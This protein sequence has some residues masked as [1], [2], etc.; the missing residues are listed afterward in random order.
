M[1]N[2]P[3]SFI[4]NDIIQSV[5]KGQKIITRFPPEPNGYMH[6]GHAKAFGLDYFLAAKYGGST[7]LRFEDTNPTKES[8][9]YVEAMKR[10]IKW[11]GMEWSHIVFISDNFEII[12]N[13][14]VEFIK[15]GLAYVD[16]QTP[17]EMNETRGTFEK[18]GVDSPH[19]NRSVKENLELF[20]K[21][22]KGE[23]K[24]GECVLR[25]KIDMQSPNLKM[26]DPA[27]YRIMFKHHMLTNDDWCIYPL[28]DYAHAMSDMLGKITHSICSLEYDDHRALYDWF[29]DHMI[30]KGAGVHDPGSPRP[31]QFEFSRLNIEQFVMSKRWLLKFVEEGVVDGWDDPRMPTISGMRRRGY[32]PMA[33]NEFVASTGVSRTP[34][35]VP[36]AQLEHFVRANLDPVVPRVSVVFNPVRV[37]ITNYTGSGEQLD[38]QNNPHKPEDGT[39]K[40]DFS[41]EI[42]ID[43]EDFIVE[44]PKGWKR[45]AP[46]LMVRLR[47]AYIIKCDEVVYKG[48]KIDHLKCT[49][50]PESKSGFDTSGVKPNGVIHY[51]DKKT[52]K[53]IVVN[54][55]FPLLKQGTALSEENI[56]PVTKASHEAFAEK[57]LV[58]G[59]G[60]KSVQFVR[61][62][63]F[64]KD[65]DGAY[66]KTV[67]L[68]G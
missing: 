4:E 41:S 35:T 29:I 67:S 59:A 36:M 37:V 39:H 55:F 23:F 2:L 62:G 46:G 49:Y 33:I 63:F 65:S 53:K 11:L 25:A 13:L 3:P 31:R 5:A 51:V 40:I 24:E 34:M 1:V 52:A 50:I 48:K 26:R 21:M 54:E 16:H 58:E 57:W 56:N 9:E 42:Y 32:P 47:G 44:P 14:A 38:I 68:K 45:L 19:R 10:D 60:D 15:K 64:I 66:N 22:R 7:T 30:E 27:M 28:Y 17:E 61:K 8:M 43:G 18:P 6:I 20:E 12:Y